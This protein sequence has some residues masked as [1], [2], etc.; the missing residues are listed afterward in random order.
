MNNHFNNST[1][2][3]KENLNALSNKDNTKS[4][5]IEIKF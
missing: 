1:T 2:L 4:K 3:S 5:E